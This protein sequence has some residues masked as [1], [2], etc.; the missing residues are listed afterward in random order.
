MLCS[1]GERL[2]GPRGRGDFH[3]SQ[4]PEG[5]EGRD[6]DIGGVFGGHLRFDSSPNSARGHQ[7]GSRRTTPL[8]LGAAVVGSTLWTFADPAKYGAAF[9]LYIAGPRFPTSRSCSPPTPPVRR[10]FGDTSGRWAWARRRFGLKRRRRLLLRATVMRRRS[11][12]SAWGGTCRCELPLVL[13][14][15]FP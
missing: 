11:L 15:R 1:R 7:G 9:W 14:S 6:P 13:N 10:R 8:G 5:H 3:R 4:R 2:P 12:R